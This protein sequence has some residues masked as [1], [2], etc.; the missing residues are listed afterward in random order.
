MGR[1]IVYR[2][3]KIDEEDGLYEEIEKHFKIYQ[4]RIFGHRV[5]V[6]YLFD[7]NYTYSLYPKIL[8]RIDKYTV[9]EWD[10]DE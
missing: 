4:Q 1:L 2:A 6:I 8:Q 5:Y 9:A 7:K 3:F 10:F